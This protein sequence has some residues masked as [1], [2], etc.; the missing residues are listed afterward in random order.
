MEN[1]T[2]F[3]LNE[4]IRRW[5]AEFGS[6]SSLSALEVEELEAHLRDHVAQL[7]AAGMKVEA[8]FSV[9]AKQLGDRQRVASE[10]AKINPQ[11]V[12]LER[13]IWMGLGVVLLTV[14]ERLAAVPG[15]AILNY[16]FTRQWHPAISFALNSVVQLGGVVSLVALLWVTVARKERWGDWLGR[17]CMQ[18]PIT[19]SAAIVLALWGSL[20]VVTYW[21]YLLE[22]VLPQVEAW[23]FP[24]VHPPFPEQAVLDR[25]SIICGSAEHVIWAAALCVLAVCVVRGRRSLPLIAGTPAVPRNALWLERLMWMDAAY[26]LVRLGAPFVHGWVMLPVK[27][28]LPALGASTLVQH[29]VGVAT[30]FLGLILWALPFWVC[31]LFARR[32]SWLGDRIRWA[33]RRHPFW[34]SVS[35]TLLLNTGLVLWPLFWWAGLHNKL[36][37]LGP[38]R[39]LDAWNYGNGMILCQHVTLAVLLVMLLRWRTKLRKA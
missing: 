6:P 37:G 26:V 29:L 13:A 1:P 22:R 16:G 18:N 15:G 34:T 39:I 31:W 35:V 23:L 2:L 9:A 3:S 36:A 21:P 27:L 5:R 11:R 12:W 30:A 32:L 28:L 10:F 19:A 8:A 20:R 4:A 7:E 25:I 17:F 24:R 14:V 33:F 38:N